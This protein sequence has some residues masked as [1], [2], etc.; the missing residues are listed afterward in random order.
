MNPK[1]N[2]IVVGFEEHRNVSLYYPIIFHELQIVPMMLSMVSR[3]DRLSTG[4]MSSITATLKKSLPAL[5]MM[6]LP[7]CPHCQR[8][9]F[10][11]KKRTIVVMITRRETTTPKMLPTRTRVLQGRSRLCQRTTY[12]LCTPIRSI[13]WIRGRW[14]LG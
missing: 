10:H 2:S 12:A 13:V 3:K 9:G 11:K 4:R 14:R 5:K 6:I 8:R 7:P 1:I